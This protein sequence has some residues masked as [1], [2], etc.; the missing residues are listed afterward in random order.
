[1]SADLSVLDVAWPTGILMRSRALT[2]TWVCG[3]IGSTQRATF[4]PFLTPSSLDHGD[5]TGWLIQTFLA[6]RLISAQAARHSGR[7]VHSCSLHFFLWS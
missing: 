7:S 5:K 1:M 3:L 6:N 4:L 2:R